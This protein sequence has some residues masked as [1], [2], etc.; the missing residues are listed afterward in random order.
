MPAISIRHWFLLLFLVLCWSSAILLTRVAVMDVSP[1]WV[2]T[3][4]VGTGALAL[5]GYRLFVVRQEWTLGWHHLP[6]IL[7]L[8]LISS[9]LPF[10][11]IAWGSQYT[12][13]AIAGILMGMVP[14]MVLGL[15][16]FLLPDEKLTRMKAFGFG[17]GF[18]GLCLVINPTDLSD[19]AMDMMEIIGQGAILLASFCYAMTTISTRRMP[20]ADTLDKATGVVS[21]AALILIIVTLAREPI[22][23]IGKIGWDM[24]LVLLYLGLVPTALAS[25]ALFRL[26]QETKASFVASSNYLI[27]VMTALGGVLF[28]GEHLAPLVWV[29]FAIIMAGLLIGQRKAQTHDRTA[30]DKA[31]NAKGDA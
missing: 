8:G 28:L 9:A 16:H 24:G 22:S 3:G 30:V 14:L 6:W 7:W 4:R 20:P 10:L 1:L 25:L 15:A 11:L 17:L 19:G 13:G 27:P 29:G 26:L 5:I 12:S 2:T 31:A 18:L 21:A 23:S